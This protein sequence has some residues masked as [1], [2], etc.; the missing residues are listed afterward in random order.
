MSDG[1]FNAV[2]AAFW[3]IASIIW[4]NLLY[5]LLSTG[6]CFYAVLKGTLPVGTCAQ[7]APNLLEMMTGG[8]AAAMA[9]SGKGTKE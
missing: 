4:F 3:L 8:L 2:R 6:V 1:T 7:F 5:S 9:F